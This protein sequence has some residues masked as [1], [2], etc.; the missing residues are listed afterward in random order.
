MREIVVE[1]M[2][3]ASRI[4]NCQTVVYYS[5]AKN[6]VIAPVSDKFL[7]SNPVSTYHASFEWFQINICQEGLAS[8]YTWGVQVL[9]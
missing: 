6:N 4:L 5:A 2:A 7:V 8:L 3:K 9:S 1:Y